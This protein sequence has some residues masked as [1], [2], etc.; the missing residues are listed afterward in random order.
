M[1]EITIT[2][3]EIVTP[4]KIIKKHSKNITLKNRVKFIFIV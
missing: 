1:I 3:A 2:R 4:L